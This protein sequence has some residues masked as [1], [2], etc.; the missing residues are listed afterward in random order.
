MSHIVQIKTQVKDAVAVEAACRRL[1]LEA[2]RYGATMLY[3]GEASGVIV[4]L[5][6]WRYPVVFNTAAGEA[7]FD[8][9]RGR[10]GEQAQLDRFLQAYAA[11]KCKLEARK[12]GHTVRPSDL[13]GLLPVLP[14]SQC[15]ACADRVP[16][17]C[18]RP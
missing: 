13:R 11:E 18:G 3:S 12:R 4:Q 8:N 17:R 1:G 14:R 2:P 7:K 9:F 10:W 16:L 15:L 5:P 6:G